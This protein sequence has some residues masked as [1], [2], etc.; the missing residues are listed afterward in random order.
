[1]NNENETITKAT[2]GDVTGYPFL[3]ISD[4]DDL[5]LGDNFKFVVKSVSLVTKDEESKPIVS[6]TGEYNG[7]TYRHDLNR[8]N[9][10]FIRDNSKY[11][12]PSKLL[13]A[14]INFHV[15]EVLNL[16]G[17]KVKGVRVQDVT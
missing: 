17:V 13:G 7:T 10:R 2:W 14:I 6:I 9:T 12:S 1:M 11:S 15:E 5:K 8:T 3:K 4:M 16:K